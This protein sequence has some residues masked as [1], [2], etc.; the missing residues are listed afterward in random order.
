M[1][2][3]KARKSTS[4]EVF[5]KENGYNAVVTCGGVHS[6]HNRAVAMMAMRNGWP[7]HLVYHG[8]KKV[9]AT[10]KGNAGLVKFTG[11]ETEFVDVNQISSAMDKAIDKY[12]AVGLNPYYIHGGGHDLPGGTAFV[13]AVKELKKQSDEKGYKPDYIFMATG[14]GSTQAG[15]AVGLDLVGWSDVKLIGISVAR[16]VE[17]GKKIVV[18][19]ANELAK[20]YELDKDYADSI[21]FVDDYIG[22]GYDK[23]SKEQATFIKRI[24]KQTGLMVDNTYSGKA[25]YGMMDYIEKQQLKGDFLFWLTGGPLNAIN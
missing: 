12:K 7:C 10:G 23:K 20:H 13:D 21:E 18:E 17:R 16:Q 8:G 5:L 1:G 4:Y 2:G 19:F 11:A 9:F 22:S 3:I 15:M 14:T 25:L 6:N 24:Y